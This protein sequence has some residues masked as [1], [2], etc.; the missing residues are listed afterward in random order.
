[1]NAR[2]GKMIN[3]PRRIVAILAAVSTGVL[4]IATAAAQSEHEK[5]LYDAARKEGQLTWYTAHYDQALAT[6]I[7]NAFT[8]KYP[9]VQANV[10]KAT[11]QVSFQR[12]LQDIKAGQVQCDLFSSTDVSHFAYLKQKGDLEKYVPENEGKIVPVFQ[13]I[14]PDGFSTVTWAGL[15]AISY[16]KDK[17]H[18]GEAPKNWPDLADPKWSGKVAV[19]DPNF[20]GMVG[21]WTVAMAKLYGWDYFKKLNQGKPLI[22]RSID[23][24]VTILNSGERVVAAADPAPTLRSAAKGNPLAV[25]YPTDGAVAVIG[26]SAIIKGAKSPNAGKLFL[27]FLLSPE[28]AKLVAENFEQSLRPDVTPPPGAKSLADVKIVRPSIEEIAKDLPANKE[29]WKETFGM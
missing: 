29:R 22:G 25:I 11:A 10:I 18:A 15:V 23:D 8:Q 20:S 21:V 4:G 2:G 28:A 24:A 19:G 14:D 17:V 9:G 7:G 3:T 5:Q 26:P 1:M 13:K 16:N 12:L 6:K 27:E